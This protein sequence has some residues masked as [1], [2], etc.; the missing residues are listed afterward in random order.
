MLSSLPSGG[1]LTRRVQHTLIHSSYPIQ[2]NSTTFFA[3]HRCCERR[4]MSSPSAALDRESGLEETVERI[5]SSP[6]K[7]VLYVTGG[8]A[9]VSDDQKRNE[10]ASGC[11]I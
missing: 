7:L 8:A 6:F 1:P 2:Y 10:I 3:K 4:R 11:Y 5:H 9:Q